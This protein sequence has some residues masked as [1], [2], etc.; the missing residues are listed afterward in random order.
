MISALPNVLTVLRLIGVPVMVVALLLDAGE[1]GAWRWAALVIFLAAAATDYLDGY[2]A[3][4]WEVVS[5]FGKLADPI[6]D[7][8]LVLAALGTLIATDGLPW[9]PV[10]IIAFREVYVTVGRLLVA[11]D[12]VI[13]ASP[14]GK[15][16]TVLQIASIALYL[17]PAAPTWML[18]TA[19]VLLL[20]ATAV[21]LYS[22][23]D[24]GIKI[25]RARREHPPQPGESR[26][27]EP[28]A[29]GFPE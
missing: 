4:R 13:A 29:G 8:A 9:W 1:Q 6:A 11:H 23:I 22:G 16:K 28:E 17:W 24:Y 7:K 20:A 25:A 15:L 12:V 5:D 26:V 14:G 2:L 3:R 18:T 27:P 10:A 19:W 21:A